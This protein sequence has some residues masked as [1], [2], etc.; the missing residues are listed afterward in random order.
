MEF[1][2]LA[3]AVLFAMLKN[4]RNV[5]LKDLEKR[6]FVRN[7]RHTVKIACIRLYHAEY[8]VFPLKTGDY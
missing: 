4:S 1:S 5:V 2:A 6:V 8:A 7:Y 3:L